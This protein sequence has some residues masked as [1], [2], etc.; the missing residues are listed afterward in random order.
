MSAEAWI[1]LLGIVVM[2][3]MALI[4][5]AL[6][7]FSK[8]LE[9]HGK[10][11]TLC[12]ENNVRCAAELAA[13]TKAHDHSQKNNKQA[14]DMHTQRHDRLESRV[15]KVENRVTRVETQIGMEHG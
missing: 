9:E 4:G 12:S 5:R 7:S 14:H 8:S 3:A 6:N 15:G 10:G 13:L 2:V 11:L 1:A